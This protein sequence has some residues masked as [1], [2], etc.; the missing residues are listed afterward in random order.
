MG[1]IRMNFINIK[2]LKIFNKLISKISIILLIIILITLSITC[3][4]KIINFIF[5]EEPITPIPTQAITLYF[6]KCGEKQCFLIEEIREVK[7]DK[8]L[9]L[10]LMEELIKGPVNKELSPTLPSST[11]VNSIT[12]EEDLVIVD[13]SKDIILD[14]EIPH[15]STTEPLA[16]FSIVNTLTELPQVKRVRILV[17]GKNEGDI[18]GMRIEDFWGHVGIYEVFERNEEIIGPKG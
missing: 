13:F 4:Q 2:P 8:E 12:I 18:N 9:Q 11:K 7:L 6:S 17:N 14:H 15:S 10:I 16:I 5:K 3:C 1:A